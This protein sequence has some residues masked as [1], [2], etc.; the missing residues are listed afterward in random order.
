MMPISDSRLVS[1]GEI[2]DNIRRLRRSA[3]MT[4]RQAADGA[5][6]SRVSYRHIES[7]KSIPKATSLLAI[8]S[9][10][11]VPIGQLLERPPILTKARFCGGLP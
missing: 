5:G 2:A 1:T 4:Q 3:G 6:M 11:G 10:L 9:A 7:G 8:A